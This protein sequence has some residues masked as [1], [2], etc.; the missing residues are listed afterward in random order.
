MC[1]CECEWLLISVLSG[2]GNGW[3]NKHSVMLDLNSIG[4][5]TH[6]LLV[7][8]IREGFWIIG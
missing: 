1:E 3:M 5:L 6:N 7:A 4:D 8:N 2:I